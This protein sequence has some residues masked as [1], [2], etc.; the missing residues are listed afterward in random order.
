MAE[1]FFVCM[2]VKL[3]CNNPYTQKKN[4]PKELRNIIVDAFAR[5]PRR[6]EGKGVTERAGS[7]RSSQSLANAPFILPNSHL[8]FR[9]SAHF[10]TFVYDN[11]YAL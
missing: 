2:V 7:E 8:I 1:A 10:I 5:A 6:A 9:F 4:T 3:A 11:M